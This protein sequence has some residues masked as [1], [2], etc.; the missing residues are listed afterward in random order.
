MKII[1]EHQVF[2]GSVLISASILIVGFNIT[3]EL[4]WV[5][6]YLD[7]IDSALESIRE[8]IFYGK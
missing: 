2:I 7:D 6:E 4:Y 8:A 1:K 3:N 5:K